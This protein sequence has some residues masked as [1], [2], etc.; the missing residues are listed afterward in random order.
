MKLKINKTS[1]EIPT[2]DNLTCRQ[3]LECLEASKSND[4][5]ILRYLSIVTGFNYVDVCN[6]NIDITTI[7]RLI[8][9][10]GQIK[11]FDYFLINQSSQILIKGNLFVSTRK[12]FD[13]ERVGVRFLFEAK[14]AETENSAELAI[15]LLVILLTPSFDYDE[16]E[17]QYSK[18]LEENYIKILSFSAFFLSNYLKTSKKEHKS[19]IMRVLAWIKNIVQR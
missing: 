6:A 4:P 14:A 11:N 1:I 12:D 18:L 5:F 16:V 7:Q 17:E 3:Y 9:W 19:L 8:A 13:V 2:A 10:I 15:Y